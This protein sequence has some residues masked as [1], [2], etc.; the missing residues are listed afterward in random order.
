MPRSTLGR[1]SLPRDRDEPGPSL[2]QPETQTRSLSSNP[3]ERCPPAVPLPAATPNGSIRDPRSGPG[4]RA[5]IYRQEP[6][7]RGQKEEQSV[8][9]ASKLQRNVP[10][11]QLDATVLPPPRSNP[12]GR[13]P[14]RSIDRENFCP[15]RSQLHPDTDGPSRSYPLRPKA[16]FS[17]VATR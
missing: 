15:A 4:P 12:L 7:R 5:T 17:L 16:I 8:P 13:V 6:S 1:F 11:R 14:A 10:P 3:E 2:R 9:R